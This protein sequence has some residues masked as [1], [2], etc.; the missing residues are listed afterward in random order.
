MG[1]VVIQHEGV[2]VVGH[3]L[4]D[5][6][7]LPSNA[8]SQMFEVVLHTRP[9]VVRRPKCLDKLRDERHVAKFGGESILVPLL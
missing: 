5:H 6:S 9:A 2:E 1:Y 3:V 8:A 7:V 4:V